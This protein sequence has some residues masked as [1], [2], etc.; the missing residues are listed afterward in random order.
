MALLWVGTAAFLIG[1]TILVFAYM[2]IL[3][4]ELM[5][6]G[7]LGGKV[8]SVIIVGGFGY[9]IYRVLEAKVF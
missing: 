1:S 8:Y 3:V 9:V 5:K 6:S 2:P 7:T 4:R